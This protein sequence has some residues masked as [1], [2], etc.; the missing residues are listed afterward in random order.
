MG[1]I[2]AAHP[3]WRPESGKISFDGN[4]LHKMNRSEARKPKKWEWGQWASALIAGLGIINTMVMSIL[5]C[6]RIS[7]CGTG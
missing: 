1:K 6:T 5:D 4:G 3:D 2:Q 7:G